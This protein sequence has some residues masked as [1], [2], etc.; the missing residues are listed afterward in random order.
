[1]SGSLTISIKGTPGA[2][3]IDSSLQVGVGK[4]FMQA[5]TSAPPTCTWQVNP[6]FLFTSVVPFVAS[7]CL[8]FAKTSMN[9]GSASGLSYCEIW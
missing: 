9:P 1:M 8:R 3:Q 5:L 4:A 7:L 2:V 6:D